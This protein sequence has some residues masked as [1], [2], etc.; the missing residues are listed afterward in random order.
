M[1]V[2]DFNNTNHTIEVIPREYPTGAITLTI[3]NRVTDATT[4]PA[5]TYV[6]TAGV[7]A[8]SF[9]YTFVEKYKYIFT[10]KEGS[11]VLFIGEFFATTQTPQ[12]YKITNGLYTS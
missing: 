3:E 7:M 4:S 11:T 12:D 6:T 8:V 1:I 9:T 10:L 5:A 2:V